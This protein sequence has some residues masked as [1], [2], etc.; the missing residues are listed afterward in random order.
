MPVRDHR[1]ALNA[2]RGF[3]ALLVVA[4]HYRY[5]SPF[6]WFEAFPALASGYLG[7]DF[8]FVLSGLVISHVYL[9]PFLAGRGSL[10]HFLFLRI[11]RLFPVHALIMIVMLICYIASGRAITGSQTVDWISLTFLVREWLVPQSYAWNSPAWS[12]S[13][14]MFA[15]TFIFP[16][17]VAIARRGE[18]DAAGLSLLGFGIA[19]LAILELTTGTLNIIPFGGPLIRVAGGFMVGAGTYCLLTTRQRSA[20]WDAAIVGGGALIPA[21]I[22]LGS[23]LA[24]LT[25]LSIITVGAYMS[26][27]KIATWL[28]NRPLHFFG[29]IS[30]S[31]YLCHVPVFAAAKNAADVL[32][33]TRGPLFCVVTTG[34]C[35]LTAVALYTLIEVPARRTLRKWW[36]VRVPVAALPAVSER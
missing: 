33:I 11:S 30:F 35:L 34:I 14:E 29:E 15:Y 5:Y 18:R 17:V 10:P 3:A 24:L 2:L 12:V 19:A 31:L 20:R 7:V 27:G 21:L 16:F 26:T 22:P 13:A 8:F 4:Y 36:D 28:A 25:A 23:D 6:P 1:P 9:D 32:G